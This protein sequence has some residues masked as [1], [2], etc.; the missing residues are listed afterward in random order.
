MSG[1]VSAS[2]PHHLTPLS[3]LPRPKQAS[4]L[5]TTLSMPC[6][7]VTPPTPSPCH[8]TDP[9][10]SVLCPPMQTIVDTHFTVV[11]ELPS[12]VVVDC[13][14][15]DNICSIIYILQNKVCVLQKMALVDHVWN[16]PFLRCRRISYIVHLMSKIWTFRVELQ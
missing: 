9:L 15:I 4:P 14:T 10:V 11:V 3:R 8:Q 5:D 16:F 1:T 12:L 6:H 2:L 7:S 13:N